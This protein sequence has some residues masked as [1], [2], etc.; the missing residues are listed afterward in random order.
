MSEWYEDLIGSTKAEVGKTEHRRA[1]VYG[2]SGTGKTLFAASAPKP[3][4]VN[5]DY[6]LLSLS[7]RG[8]DVKKI[9]IPPMMKGIYKNLMKLISDATNRTGAFAPGG[10][11]ADCETF[12]LDSITGLANEQFLWD[13][14]FHEGNRKPTEVKAQ[15]DDY[16]AIR[17]RLQTLVS[18]LKALPMN[19]IVIAEAMIE[20]DEDTGKKLGTVNLLGSY[21]RAIVGA[22]DYAF[23]FTTEQ[24]VKDG[25][26]VNVWGARTRPFQYWTAKTRSDD[27]MPEYVIDPTW[28]KLFPKKGSKS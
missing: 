21:R 13:I 19:V 6:G 7:E 8:I 15:F 28:D 16:S 22:F 4:F 26:R 24:V 11:F 27:S 25:A 2:N 5:I 17:F 20:D 12:V 14:M 1:L 9:D 3:L 18:A 23:L 10:A